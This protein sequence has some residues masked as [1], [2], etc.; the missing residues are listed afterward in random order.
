MS[1]FRDM[2]LQTLQIIVIKAETKDNILKPS[3][4]YSPSR[5]K[6]TTFD[7]LLFKGHTIIVPTSL[8]KETLD[9]IKLM[10]GLKDLTMLHASCICLYFLNYIS[11]DL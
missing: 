6:I 1:V 7:C 2:E 5:D 3:Y 10:F 11:D 9:C 4:L 8:Q